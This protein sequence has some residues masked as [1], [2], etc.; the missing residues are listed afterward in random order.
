MNTH[1]QGWLVAAISTALLLSGC[2]GGGGGSPS[3]STTS[4]AAHTTATPSPDPQL[5]LPYYKATYVDGYVS[6]VDHLSVASTTQLPSKALV[7]GGNITLM[8]TDHRYLGAGS[9]YDTTAQTET[10]SSGVVRYDGSHF[11]FYLSAGQ[12]YRL[13]LTSPTAPLPVKVGNIGLT[14]LCSI[15]TE[16]T[17]QLGKQGTVVVSGFDTPGATASSCGSATQKSWVVPIMA[18]SSTPTPPLGFYVMPLFAF[19]SST[20]TNGYLTESASG[21]LYVTKDLS[22]QGVQVKDAQGNAL[23]G[24]IVDVLDKS[25]DGQHIFVNIT[26]YQ[27]STAGTST[28]YSIS[29]T[30]VATLVYSFDHPYSEMTGNSDANGDLFLFDARPPVSGSTSGALNIYKAAP[31]GGTATQLTQITVPNVTAAFSLY[32]YQVSSDGQKL[33]VT[34]TT[35]QSP[36]TEKSFAYDISTGVSTAIAAVDNQT[37]YYY[38]FGSVST[39]VFS[40]STVSGLQIY[41]M[42]TEAVTGT[43]NGYLYGGGSVGDVYLTNNRHAIFSRDIIVGPEVVPP[44]LMGINNNPPSIQACYAMSLPIDFIDM[45]TGSTR[46]SFT[47][48]NNNCVTTGTSIAQANIDFLSGKT[49]DVSSKLGRLFVVAPA[50]NAPL[51]TTIE[52]DTPATTVNGKTYAEQWSFAD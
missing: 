9:Q 12:L 31:G 4:S 42:G 17:D 25:G 13:D 39:L 46:A 20:A 47:A 40:N 22:K 8:T 18:D 43:V 52:T 23:S 35:N 51:V 11:F 44:Y 49:Y 48:P 50:L 14:Q 33:I 41:N 5:W 2:G 21:A 15:N 32:A 30:G 16:Q 1:K 38:P 37:P 3:A 6:I 27:V 24:G 36:L 26:H 10:D 28:I 19:Q 45:S 29:D 34:V 7:T